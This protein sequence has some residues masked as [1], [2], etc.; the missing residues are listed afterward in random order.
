MAVK[1][2]RRAHSTTTATDFSFCYRTGVFFWRLLWVRPGLLEGLPFVIADMRCRYVCMMYVVSEKQR[3][4][5]AGKRRTTCDAWRIAL[6]CWRIRTRRWLANSSRWR[7]CT[8]RKR[9][10]H[11]ASG[12]LSRR[13]LHFAS[14]SLRGTLSEETPSCCSVTMLLW[15]TWSIFWLP[16]F[17][18]SLCD[19]GW[20]GRRTELLLRLSHR[21]LQPARSCLLPCELF[22]RNFNVIWLL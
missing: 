16:S 21:T 11:R 7:S 4:N 2:E 9:H 14:M 13:L 18:D 12:L 17:R 10:R 19:V 15:L 3:K 5:V 22:C 1:M 8:A 6:R 20:P